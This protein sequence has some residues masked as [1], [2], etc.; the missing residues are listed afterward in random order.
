MMALPLSAAHILQF[1][2]RIRLPFSFS[3]FIVLSSITGA[4]LLCVPYPAFAE[5]RATAS[6]VDFG[7]RL[8]NEPYRLVRTLQAIQDR[9]AYGSNEALKLQSP[10]L[11]QIEQQ[12][13]AAPIAVWQQPRNARA[14]ITFALSGGSPA[15]LRKLDQLTPPPAIAPE[16]LKGVLAYVA[17]NEENARKYLENIDPRTLAPGINGRIALVQAALLARTD[18]EKAMASLDLSRLLLPGTLVDEGALRREVF[19]AGQLGLNQKFKALAKHYLQRYPNSAYAND[20]HLR[21]S[22]AL[23]RLDLSGTPE[24]E[25]WLSD[26]LAALDVPSQ[27]NINLTLTKQ[28]ISEGKTR[29]ATLGAKRVMEIAP[30]ATAAMERAK[31]YFAAATILNED[32]FISSKQILLSLNRSL[33]PADDMS[34]LGSALYIAN[35]I[36]DLPNNSAVASA[37]TP[38][39]P[40]VQTPP[41]NAI[42]EVRGFENTPA[43]GATVNRIQQLIGD[44]DKILDEDLGS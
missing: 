7:Q 43:L 14:A 41:V 39:A 40:A 25:Q 9:T 30:A 28:A 5:S 19:L 1:A 24:E 26:L 2:R 44:S 8:A 10:L 37:Q 34:L 38:A 18:P 22:A 42:K 21:F 36:R 27:M 35:R 32:D 29:M 11:S 4:I 33:L 17:G 13:L 20:F 16:L 6:T 15:I 3:I 31:L 12:L 23:V